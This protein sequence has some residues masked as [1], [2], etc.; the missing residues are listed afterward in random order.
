MRTEPAAAFSTRNARVWRAKGI[1]G[2]ANVAY[3]ASSNSLAGSVNVKGEGA[4][5]LPAAASLNNMFAGCSGLTEPD[6]PSRNGLPS[7]TM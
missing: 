1:G 7:S 2:F 5:T 3:P 4:Q 6:F